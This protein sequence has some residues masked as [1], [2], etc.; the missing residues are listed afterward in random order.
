MATL[1]EPIDVGAVTVR[2]RAVVTAHGA[3]LDFYRPG[4]SADRYAGYLEARARGGAGLIILQPVHVHPSSHALGHH[5]Y[6]RDD[7]APK[8]AHVADRLHRHDTTAL[9][10][11]FHFGAQFTSDG[12]EDL[13]P[14][15]SFD[16]QPSPEGEGSHRMTGVEI[17]EVLDGYVRTAVLAVESGLDG[18][19]LHATHGYLLQQSFSP[20]GNDR[21][22]EWGEP[23]RFAR[24]LIAR[25]R[26]AL[27]AEHV[28]GL[29]ISADDWVRPDQGGLGA[30]GLQ[31]VAAALVA[32]GGLDYLNHSEG[33][34]SSHYA[35]SIGNYRH[36]HGEWLPLTGGLRQAIDAAVPVIGVGKLHT[37]DDAEAALAAGVCDMVAMTRAHI[38]DPDVITKYS[39]RRTA[40]IR[41]C[42]GANQG[43]VDRMVGAL[44]ITCFHNPDVGR[45]HRLAPVRRNG[46]AK[47]LVVGAGPAGLKAAE[48]AAVRGHRVTVVDAAS[49]PGGR[50]LALER[51]GPAAELL[52]SVRHLVDRCKDLGVEMRLGEHLDDVP[53]GYGAVVLATGASPDPASLGVGDG[54][55]PVL[56]TDDAA[57]GRLDG[58]P[59]DVSGA[60]ILVV[61]HLG[62]NEVALAAES[63]VARGAQ[64]T[65][66]TPGPSPMWAVGFTHLRA[67][68]EALHVEGSTVESSTGFVDIANGAVT[69]RHVYSKQR[70]TRPFDA[71][72][73]GVHARAN[74]ALRASAEATGAHVHLAGDAV[75]PRTAMHAFRE[76]A[77]VGAAVGG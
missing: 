20:W 6:D 50:L 7:L 10:Q 16:G 40:E 11:L 9:V 48:A 74:T 67:L 31:D 64:V 27:G 70:S 71:V 77:D 47:V 41:P 23:L 37:P 30:E 29:R 46:S 62:T 43:C 69:T 54:S 3:F 57:W 1:L 60:G 63:L 19:E 39:S 52:D 13:Q 72:V 73:A 14:L 68:M 32:D 38:A 28:V 65:F 25:V 33:A 55:V 15:W 66:I 17:E 26:A 61:D 34:K 45:E 75:A 51:C 35:R 4:E 5:V 59:F 44:P 56:S 76:G 24:E 8:W 12:R 2:N 53:A 42:V 21:D 49:R 36:P 18:V 58:Q 22:D